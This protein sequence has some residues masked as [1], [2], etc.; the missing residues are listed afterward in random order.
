MRRSWHA[1]GGRS[2]AA[3]VSLSFSRTRTRFLASFDSSS[4]RSASFS[5]EVFLFWKAQRTSVPILKGLTEVDPDG[6]VMVACCGTTEKPSSSIQR[7]ALLEGLTEIGCDVVVAAGMT[8]VNSEFV[9]GKRKSLPLTSPKRAG[10]WSFVSS[11][12]YPLWIRS[13]CFDNRNC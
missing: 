12:S 4:S 6:M 3:G 7:L 9:I 5:N 8:D 13:R 1:F 11:P 10:F 2:S